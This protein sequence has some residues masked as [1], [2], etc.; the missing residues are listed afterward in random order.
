MAFRDITCKK[1]IAKIQSFMIECYKHKAERFF[2][3]IV[4]CLTISLIA[5][6][7]I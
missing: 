7:K 1:L 4:F 5:W 2:D 3:F 6:R